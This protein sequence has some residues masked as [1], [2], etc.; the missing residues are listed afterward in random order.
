MPFGIP[1]ITFYKKKKK[2][3]IKSK[4]KEIKGRIIN[5]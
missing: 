5:T 4:R 2:E 3:W 1:E